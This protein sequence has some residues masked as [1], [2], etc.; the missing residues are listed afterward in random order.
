MDGPPER[1]GVLAVFGKN[2]HLVRRHALF[3]ITVVIPVLL[4][5][6]YYGLIASDVYVS[7]SKYLV[8]SPEK[9]TT[10]GLGMILRSAGFSQASEEVY[11]VRDY[12][13]SRDALRALNEKSAIY[14]AYTLPHISLFDRFSSIGSKQSFEDL[15]KYYGKKVKIEHDSSTSISTLT[16]RAYT[17]KDAHD[18]NERLLGLSET[19]VNRLNQRGRSDLIR[20]ATAEVE[21]AQTRA[22]AAA[23]ALAVFRNRSGVVD[24]EK[25]API[26][27]QLISK[28]QDDLI[29]TRSQLA[30][31]RAAAPQ[32]PQIESLEAQIASLEAAISR[33]ESKVTGAGGSLAGAAAQYQ[34]LSL[35]SQFADRQLA[36]AMASLEQA[37]NE[38]RRKQVYLERIVQ[39]SL[40][41]VATEPRRMRGV[42]S[43]L[44]IGVIAW[45]ILSMLLAGVREHQG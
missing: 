44:V 29:A 45:G 43:T 16:V 3:L 32:N 1:A 2:E 25:Q 33:E 10:A 28:L 22:K 5:V 17:A 41:D 9:Q 26:Q 18:F 12:A 31:L 36:S 38:A 42:L 6:L 4:S 24:P 27:L 11:A 13:Q 30:Q 40:P 35:E 37:R 21:D 20:F 7:E 8:S 19:L 34:R 23:V 39:P 14:R 15:F